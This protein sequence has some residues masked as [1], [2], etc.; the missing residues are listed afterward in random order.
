[1]IIEI[2]GLLFLISLTVIFLGHYMNVEVLKIVGYGFVFLLGFTLLNGDLKYHDGDNLTH[3]PTTSQVT[4]LYSSYQN[5][6]F[7]LYTCVMA[8]FGFVAVF[9]QWKQKRL[10]E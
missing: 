7:G 10:G 1:M 8:M 5:I 9:F 4:P 6:Q 3:T 2:F